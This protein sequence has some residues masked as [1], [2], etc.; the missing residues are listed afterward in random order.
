VSTHI[1]DTFPDR[2]AFLAGL[3]VE[4]GRFVAR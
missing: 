1:T 2:E 3:A 4:V